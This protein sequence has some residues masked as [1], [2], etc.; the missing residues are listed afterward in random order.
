[1]W[2]HFLLL[3][4]GNLFFTIFYFEEQ[5]IS[6]KSKF[7]S[8]EHSYIKYLLWPILSWKQPSKT[9]DKHYVP[10]GKPVLY[11]KYTIQYIYIY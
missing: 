2:S 3:N 11:T 6:N 7:L 5:T 9:T 4:N 1:M 8:D 10:I